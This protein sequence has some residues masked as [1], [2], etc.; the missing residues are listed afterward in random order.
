MRKLLLAAGLGCVALLVARTVAIRC[1]AACGGCGCARGRCACR[2]ATE[3]GSSDA[4]A[5]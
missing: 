5:S 4:T 3:A 2:R 1:R